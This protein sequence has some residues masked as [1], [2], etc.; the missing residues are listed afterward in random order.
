MDQ[1]DELYADITEV[2]AETSEE[3]L[4]KFFSGEELTL[5]EIKMVYELAL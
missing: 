5:E 3:M 1:I 2:V 4:E